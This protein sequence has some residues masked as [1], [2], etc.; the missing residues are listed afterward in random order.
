VSREK[1]KF[2]GFSKL[3]RNIQLILHKYIKNIVAISRHL[4]S[5]Q[6]AGDWVS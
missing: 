4:F 1:N 6:E 2:H 5:G 3:E